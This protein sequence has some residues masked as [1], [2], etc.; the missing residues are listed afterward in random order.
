MTDKIKSLD[1]SRSVVIQIVMKH[2]EDWP[3]DVPFLFSI[4]KDATSE[5][6]HRMNMKLGET[7]N[8]L[9]CAL[10]MIHP[11]ARQR[12]SPEYQ[13]ACERMIGNSIGING[14]EIER[15]F[16]ERINLS[17]VLEPP[18]PPPKRRLDGF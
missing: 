18:K 5:A 12:F 10:M 14:N 13:A 16:L 4:L 15:Q 2:V 9:S 17:K 3:E 6:V 11:K 1:E 8:A 7:Q